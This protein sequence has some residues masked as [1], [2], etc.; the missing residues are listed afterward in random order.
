MNKEVVGRGRRFKDGLRGWFGLFVL[1]KEITSCML[2]GMIHYRKNKCVVEREEK[3]YNDSLSG[4][5]GIG[6]RA[7]T[8][9]LA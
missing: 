3:S 9:A 1:K 2:L 6:S 8:E 5:E 7:Q 4:Q